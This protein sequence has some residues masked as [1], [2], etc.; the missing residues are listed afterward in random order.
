[1]MS[2]EPHYEP[3][4][5]DDDIALMLRV[6][7]GDTAAFSLLMTRYE[8][9]VLNFFLRMGVQYDVEDLT[10]QTFL[11]LYNYRHR[12]EPRAKVTTFLF[13]LARQVWID[14]LRKRSR[15]KRLADSLAQEAQGATARSAAEE[16]AASGA[17]DLEQALATLPENMRLVIELG[18]YQ[19]LPYSEI[20]EILEI[21]EGTVK[22]RMFNALA[23][24]RTLLADPGSGK[25][26]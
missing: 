3:P 25:R 7:D 13:L 22:S 17:T 6:R 14:E 16:V 11:R 2:S 1:M 18:V 4:P 24:L 8:K 15:R 20:A 19:D 10:Q 23:H 5:T 21:P 26:R 12:Y 9:K